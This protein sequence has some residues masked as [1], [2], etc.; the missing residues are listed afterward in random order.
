MF[1][2][3]VPAIDIRSH[4]FFVRLAAV[5][6]CGKSCVH[7]ANTASMDSEQAMRFQHM[8]KHI[9][10]DS[11]V[12]KPSPTVVQ[13]H[14]GDK[15][16]YHHKLEARQRVNLHDSPSSLS[17]P[18]LLPQSSIFHL[19][20]VAYFRPHEPLSATI[21]SS[22]IVNQKTSCLSFFETSSE[23]LQPGEG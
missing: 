22:P 20:F 1:R 5:L 7:S 11:F 2:D 19:F 17:S 23:V 13:I 18:A 10:I 21:S 9:D 4:V 12:T 16:Q 15:V 8:V 6:Q 3:N 14:S